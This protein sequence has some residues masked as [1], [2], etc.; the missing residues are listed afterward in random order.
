MFSQHPHEVFEYPHEDDYDSS[1][2]ELTSDEY[3]E[4]EDGEEGKGVARGDNEDEPD[5]ADFIEHE[6][7]VIE[8]HVEEYPCFPNLSIPLPLLLTLTLPLPPLLIHL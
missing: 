2:G 8:K 6:D 3:D 7:E 1:G 5:E 4:E